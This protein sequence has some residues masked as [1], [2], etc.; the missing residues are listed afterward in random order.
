MRKKFIIFIDGS[1]MFSYIQLEL[2]SLKV[3]RCETLKRMVISKHRSLSNIEHKG[4]YV[5]ILNGL[6]TGE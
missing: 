3:L 5:M 2:Q 1:V 4:C 6:R